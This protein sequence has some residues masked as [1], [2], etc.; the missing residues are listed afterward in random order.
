MSNKFMITE[1]LHDSIEQTSVS[2]NSSSITSTP[3]LTYFI[4]LISSENSPC[5]NSVINNF[6]LYNSNLSNS[7]NSIRHYDHI[8]QHKNCVIPTGLYSATMNLLNS[9]VYTKCLSNIVK[10]DIENQLFNQP[11]QNDSENQIKSNNNYLKD[12]YHH[13]Q[14]SHNDQQF[15][16]EFL[17]LLNLMIYKQTN[18]ND[19]LQIKLFEDNKCNNEYDNNVL[20]INDAE[21]NSSNNCQKFNQTSQSKHQGNVWPIIFKE[22]RFTCSPTITSENYHQH[23]SSGSSNQFL[24]SN[25]LFSCESSVNYASVLDV[26]KSDA[27]LSQIRCFKSDTNT[28]I[29]SDD[30]KQ[31]V[32]RKLRKSFLSK[33][34]Q[35]SEYERKPRQAYSTDQLERLETEFEKDKYLKLNKRIELSNE[36]NLTETQIKTWFQNRRTKWK[37]KLYCLNSTSQLSVNSVKHGNS[38]WSIT[39]KS[40]SNSEQQSTVNNYYSGFVSTQF[41]S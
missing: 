31:L 3:L 5:T 29:S 15:S 34:N 21:K 1:I 8:D 27:D 26:S 17:K 13:H 40:T 6:T 16:Q 14:H 32:K 2:V 7:T 25:Y 22:L 10:Y 38:L 33:I 19:C 30:K 41:P 28:K 35:R 23:N 24:K 11:T 9:K 36:L 37:K 18:E 39:N 12:Y 20:L 4:N